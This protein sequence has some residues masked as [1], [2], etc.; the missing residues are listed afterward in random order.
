MAH[1][2][3]LVFA[4]SAI[5]FIVLIGV[6]SVI[7]SAFAP[8]HT[9]T[10]EPVGT[11]L[12]IV[13][14]DQKVYTWTDNVFIT[15]IDLDSNQNSQVIET[16][17]DAENSWVSITTGSGTLE[18]YRLD[19]T[20]TDT[21]IYTGVVR[22]SGDGT[23]GTTG[24]TGGTGP[25][26]GSIIAR[27]GDRTV[28][29]YTTPY[30]T[31]STGA[32][33]TW[34]EGSIEFLDTN[35]I[36]ETISIVRVYDPDMNLDP[37]IKD[38]VFVR[39]VSGVYGVGDAYELTEVN[40]SAGIFEGPIIFA[41]AGG[42]TVGYDDKTLPSTWTGT[43]IT[44]YTQVDVFE[45]ELDVMPPQM[46]IPPVDS[47]G[48][49]IPDV[50]DLCDSF[51][52]NFNGIEDED[53][54]P[55]TF[56]TVIKQVITNDGNNLTPDDFSLVLDGKQVQSGVAT[57]VEPGQHVAAESIVYTGFKRTV[58]GDCDEA[59]RITVEP[60]DNK[61]CIITN[62]YIA[63]FQEIPTSE[64]EPEPELTCED[65]CNQDWG[66]C[67]KYVFTAYEASGCNSTERACLYVCRGPIPE[68]EPVLSCEE[69]CKQDVNDCIA[70]RGNRDDCFSLYNDCNVECRGP[71]LEPEDDEE[72]MTVDDWF[73]EYVPENATQQ[74]LGQGW[75]KIRHI[76][77]ESKRLCGGQCSADY[78]ACVE[79]G[80]AEEKCQFLFNDCILNCVSQ[81]EPEQ[82]SECTEYCMTKLTECLESDE[83]P[84]Y[85]Y[86][87]WKFCVEW[88]CGEELRP[89]DDEDEMTVD[90]WF[91]E[92]VPGNST[93]QEL[94]IGWSK[95]RHIQPESEL[96]PVTPLS[97][98]SQCVKNWD[99][100]IADGGSR[101]ACDDIIEECSAECKRLQI[102]PTRVPFWIKNNALWYS[103]GAIGEDEFVSGIQ[104]MMQE[105][106]IDIPDLPQRASDVA[107][108]KV[109]DWVKNNAGWWADGLISE[110]D[111]VNGLKYLV[112]KGIIKV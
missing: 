71:Q 98:E 104:H 17:G 93:R 69:K 14:L 63:S 100:C 86:M 108:Q 13:E 37:N 78:N 83:Y 110:D 27:S 15:V 9:S 89:E 74:K 44:Q 85:C 58:S 11:F 7:P 48:D 19:E 10:E 52:E 112:E 75:S 106:I 18:G 90:D 26:D 81:I 21:G 72:E 22:L 95:I 53:G 62:E 68:T 88:R 54:C 46:S 60:G 45:P 29:S 70:A 91:Q 34:N 39:I 8:E 49:G 31:T 32:D 87:L 2:P 105:K 33:V 77:P 4:L 41:R 43:D 92:Y 73:Q 97:C 38:R 111:F 5:L 35:I 84:A 101:D 64:P 102:E 99:K 47:D 16:I 76:E 56:I 59:G 107:E 24:M 57:R 3:V 67:M 55:E 30:R 12:A 42:Y 79:S 40:E 61:K 6:F 1:K 25:I 82:E 65:Q 94:G 36:A 80:K 51:P 50:D 66:D 23:L 20:G 28:V 103:E 96:S 109:P